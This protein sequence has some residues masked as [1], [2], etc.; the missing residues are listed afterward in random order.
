VPQPGIFAKDLVRR[1]G[2]PPW[3]QPMGGVDM[4]LRTMNSMTGEK[5]L[6]IPME[7]KK[8]RWYTCGPTV[9]DVAHMG[10]ARAYLTFDILRRIMADHFGYDLSFQINITDIDDKIILRSRQNKLFDDFSKE[11]EKMDEAALR[12]E[13]DAAVDFVAKK[14][15]AKRP[16]EPDASATGREKEEYTKLCQEFELKK[17]QHQE[18]VKKVAA[19][20]G[21][22]ALLEAARE[23]IMG[24]LDKAKGHTVTDHA[25]FNNHA[26]HFEDEF[27]Q[28]IDNLG[29]LRPDVCTRISDF[30]DGRVQKFIE[31]L[32]D[33]GVCYESNGS[34]YFSIDEFVKKGYVY[35]KCCPAVSTSAAEMEEGEG[36][37][38]AE[39]AEKRNP[40]DFAV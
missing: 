16:K 11:A 18:L 10:H 32:E 12:K 28:D 6:F 1:E 20:S 21:K 25:I 30:M 34:V 23:P 3:Y 19:A 40:N 33:K 9:Y 24:M 4:G 22:Q 38:A 17:G 13:A 36:A 15:E 31:K 8:V 39:G 29:V 2:H 27:F 7:G 14:L 35:R 5:E 37:L 26:R